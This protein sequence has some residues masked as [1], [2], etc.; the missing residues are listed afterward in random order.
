[1]DFTEVTVLCPA[2]TTAST[3]HVTSLLRLARLVAKAACTMGP[4]V[5]ALVTRIVWAA[6]AAGPDIVC[7]DVTSVS[8]ATSVS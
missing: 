5:T 8:M 7:Q 1:M 3:K 6:S 2:I 4:H